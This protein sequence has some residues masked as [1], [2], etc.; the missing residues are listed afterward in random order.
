[1]RKLILAGCFLPLL[2]SGCASGLEPHL[3]EAPTAGFDLVDLSR[4]D[5]KAYRADYAACASLAN[6]GQ[7]DLS[8]GAVQV[9][10]NAAE[11]ASMG[12]VNGGSHKHADR[13]TVLKRCLTGR[14]YQVVR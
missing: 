2:L 10:G 8:R 9:P 6:Q 14:G 5:E 4:V 13:M 3:S 12:L 1:M 11:K 7:L